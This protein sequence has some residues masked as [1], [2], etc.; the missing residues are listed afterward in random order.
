MTDIAGHPVPDQAAAADPAAPAD[1]EPDGR[2]LRRAMNREAVVDALLDL[3][4]EG[5][6]R[7]GTDEIAE[8]AGIS[9]RSLFRYFEDTDDLVGEAIT[10]QLARTLP[11]VQVDADVAAPFQDRVRA[12][13]D[14]RFRLFD[15]AGQA[16]YATRLRAPF[17]PRLAEILAESRRFLRGQLRSLF[18]GELADMGVGRAE[19]ALAAA[20][21]LAT[22]ESYQLL[23]TDQG[24]SAAE[25]KLV[26]VESLAALLSPG[27]PR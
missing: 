20:D 15:A 10:R 13:V 17:Q 4:R 2:R 9:P 24:F 23:T 1:V 14:Q 6:L 5:S 19:W 12:L 16:A 26:I 7:P 21:V 22:F 18:A 25:A 27:G 8:R 3:Y 11:I